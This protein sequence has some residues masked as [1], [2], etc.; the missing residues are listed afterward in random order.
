M[1]G[2]PSNEASS[3]P[4]LRSY[5]AALPIKHRGPGSSRRRVSFRTRSAVGRSAALGRARRLAHHHEAFSLAG[6]LALASVGGRLTAA[7]ALTGID[8]ETF[9]LVVAGGGSWRHWSR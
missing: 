8:A 9:H 5:I 2:R 4:R 3:R 6:I 1:P 7:M